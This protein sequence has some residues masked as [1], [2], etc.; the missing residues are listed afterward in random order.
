MLIDG[1]GADTFLFGATDQQGV[2]S[3]NNTIRDF[4]DGDI[5][6]IHG[7]GNTFYGSYSGK[8]PFD[9]L[10]IEQNGDDAVITLGWLTDSTHCSAFGLRCQRADSG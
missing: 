10:I 1:A 9:D 4:E 3:G 7:D 5:I 2:D 8:K 6:E